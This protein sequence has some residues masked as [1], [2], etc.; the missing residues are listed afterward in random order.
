MVDVV[1]SRHFWIGPGT[2]ERMTPSLPSSLTLLVGLWLGFAPFVVHFGL[3]DPSGFV[4]I[5]DVV[6]A[7]V[8]SVLAMI[9]MTAPKDLPVLSL[10]NAAAGVWLAGTAFLF[11]ASGHPVRAVVNDV[12]CGVLLVALGVTSAV[13]TYRQRAAARR[14]AGVARRV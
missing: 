6:L 7:I 2:E 8:V 9:R 5:D 10:I 3:A 12:V 14:E 13:L 4:D 11:S 1:T